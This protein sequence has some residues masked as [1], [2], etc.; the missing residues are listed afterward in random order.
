[1]KQSLVPSLETPEILIHVSGDLSLEGWQNREVSVHCGSSDGPV[2]RE[3]DELIRIDCRDDCK[4]SVPAGSTIQVKHVGGDAGLKNL[5]GSLTIGKIGGDLDLENVAQ[6]SLETVGGDT[7]MIRVGGD[8]RAGKV[9]G[10]LN[11]SAVQ[12]GVQI[13]RVGGDLSLKDCRSVQAS[14]GGDISVRV[15]QAGSQGSSAPGWR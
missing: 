13:D 8:I 15:N 11:G 2:V 6:V 3:E 10:D 7:G 5:S 1:M 4:V 12:G 9:G 14:A